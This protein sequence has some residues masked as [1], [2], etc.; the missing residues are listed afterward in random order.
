MYLTEHFRL[1]ELTAS[2]TARARG[3]D[4]TPPVEAVV[5]LYHL[6]EHVLEPARRHF[7][8]PLLVSSGYRCAALNRAVGGVSRSQHL[9]GEAADIQLPSGV[10]C[11]LDDLFSWLRTHTPFDQL[12]L[13]RSASGTRWIHVSCRRPPGVNRGEVIS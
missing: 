7:G 9:I 13:E 5:N 3:I 12:I 11:T 1:S 2:A 8:V 4:N 6:C 10:S